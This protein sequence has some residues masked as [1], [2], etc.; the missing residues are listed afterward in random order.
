[1]WRSVDEGRWLVFRTCRVER[2]V[3]D[4]WCILSSQRLLLVNQI[5]YWQYL[6]MLF[7]FCMWLY[8]FKQVLEECF[9]TYDCRQEFADLDISETPWINATVLSSS[10]LF[11]E[12]CLLKC[13]GN[14]NPSLVT[15]C[16]SYLCWDA[17]ICKTTYMIYMFH[18]IVYMKILLIHD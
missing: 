11:L 17:S 8:M 15:S 2:S 6:L 3:D 10:F 5:C 14:P 18:K 1:M 9:L 16:I 13:Q 4:G 7:D 12:Y